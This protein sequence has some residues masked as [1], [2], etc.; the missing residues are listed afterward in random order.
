M[1]RREGSQVNVLSIQE[2][3]LDR[4]AQLIGIPAEALQATIERFNGFCDAGRDEDFH[5]GEP[6]WER[7]KSG[8]G[9][10]AFG[11]IEEPP[12]YALSL[13]RSTVGTKGGARTNDKAQALR[14]DDSV[15][16]GLF[17]AGNVMAN[18]IGTRAVGAGTTLG[19]CMTWGF[20]AAGTALGQI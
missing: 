7:Y 13:N 18:P 14:A 1:L 2:S 17:C 10:K 4:L 5:R 6:V 3:T 19:P 20:V 11:K 15:I 8:H 16:D 12:F 9:A